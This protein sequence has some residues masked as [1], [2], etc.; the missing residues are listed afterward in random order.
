MSAAAI[1][2]AFRPSGSVAPA[3]SAAAF[4]A[5]PA[6]STP[7][8]SS[9]GWQTTPAW[10]KTSA[11]RSA[12]DGECDAHTSPAPDSTIS[13]AC[14]GPPMQAT[15]SMPNARSSAVVGGVPSGG[16]SPLV[17]ETIPARRGTPCDCSSTSACASP[18]DGTATKTRSARSN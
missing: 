6:S 13:I 5:Q 10:W 9:D 11:T 15:R 12:S 1:P 14:A 16:T 18:A 7:T 2:A 4:F 17:S 8:G 3:A